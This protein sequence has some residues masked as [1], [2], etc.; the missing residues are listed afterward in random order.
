MA[1]PV[2]ELAVAAELI[3]P[4][5]DGSADRGIDLHRERGVAVERREHVLDREVD[6]RA[7][8]VCEYDD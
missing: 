1:T 7:F 8:R 5:A 3:T 6:H 2:G 4:L